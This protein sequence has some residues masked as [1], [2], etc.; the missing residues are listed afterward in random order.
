MHLLLIGPPGSGKGTQAHKLSTLFDLEHIS[1]GGLLRHNPNLTD[2]QKEIINSGNLIPDEMMLEIV[3]AKIHSTH[4]KGWILDGFPR[5]KNQATL[6][7]SILDEK[8]ITIIYLDVDKNELLERITGRISCQNCGTVYHKQTKPPIKNGVCDECGGHLEHR[9][10]DNQKT[11][12]HRLETYYIHTE[13]VINY[14][15]EKN[16]LHSVPSSNSHSIEEV[17][18]RIKKILK[19]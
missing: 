2:E 5:T 14:Y 13:P 7:S 18:E 19:R 1:T 17:F 10:D 11:L 6:L 16:L 3:K 4:K 15:K 12:T 8:K 9:A